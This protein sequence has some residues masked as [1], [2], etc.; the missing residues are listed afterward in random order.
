M[1][2]DDNCVI[3]NDYKKRRAES[4]KLHKPVNQKERLIIALLVAATALIA[5]TTILKNNARS[6]PINSNLS[7]SLPSQHN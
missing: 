6:N 7:S 3:Y 1:K 4:I 5:T 2:R